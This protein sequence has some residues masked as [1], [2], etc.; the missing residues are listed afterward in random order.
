MFFKAAPLLVQP[1]TA[2]LVSYPQVNVRPYIQYA[3]HTEI[4][5]CHT[6]NHELATKNIKNPSFIEERHSSS[7]RPAGGWFD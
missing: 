4:Y 7:Y 2:S 3:M 1:A 6:T 5:L